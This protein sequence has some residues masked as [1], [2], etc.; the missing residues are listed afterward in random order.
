MNQKQLQAVYSQYLNTEGK[1]SLPEKITKLV[2][3]SGRDKW[4]NRSHADTVIDFTVALAA[5]CI[6]LD[7]PE[8]AKRV[9]W[10]GFYLLNGSKIRHPQRWY[11]DFGCMCDIAERIGSL[12]NDLGLPDIAQGVGLATSCPSSPR[13]Y[14]PNTSPKEV[15]PESAK[16]SARWWAEKLLKEEEIFRDRTYGSYY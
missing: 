13:R 11:E 2:G 16:E 7:K 10:G 15:P 5:V 14:R 6:L 12:A 8:E 3:S 4:T 1:V 9:L